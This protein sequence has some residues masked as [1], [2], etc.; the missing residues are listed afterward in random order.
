MNWGLQP[1]PPTRSLK[2]SWKEP[3]CSM[4][5]DFKFLSLFGT[6]YQELRGSFCNLLLPPLTHLFNL[7]SALFWLCHFFS[8]AILALITVFFDHP[9]VGTIFAVLPKLTIPASCTHILHSI[10]VPLFSSLSYLFQHSPFPQFS[11]I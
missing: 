9:F 1:P 10:S 3:F 2:W 6:P 8:F 7:E 11:L 4:S 5:W